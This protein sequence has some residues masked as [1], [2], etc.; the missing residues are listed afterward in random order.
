MVCSTLH[1]AADVMLSRPL[2][3]TPFLYAIS[4]STD[5]GLTPYFTPIF[6]FTVEVYSLESYCGRFT[7]TMETGVFSSLS[8]LLSVLLAAI[9]LRNHIKKKWALR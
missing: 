2:H 1:V 5:I 6:N 4:I 9:L 3:F 7:Q 8:T